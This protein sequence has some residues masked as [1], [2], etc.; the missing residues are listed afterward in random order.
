MSLVSSSKSPFY[1][2]F[3]VVSE[4]FELSAVVRI[5]CAG[6]FMLLLPLLFPMLGFIF[7]PLYPPPPVCDDDDPPA[8]EV[9]CV[10]CVDPVDPTMHLLLYIPRTDVVVDDAV[11]RMLLATAVEEIDVLVIVVAV[12][13]I[14]DDVDEFIRTFFDGTTDVAA[15]VGDDVVEDRA[16]TTTPDLCCEIENCFPE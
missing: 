13:V 15:L 6:D 16:D 8:D 4:Y 5:D 3:F 9:V 10:A 14:D 11:P 1:D 2:K 7:P 12:V